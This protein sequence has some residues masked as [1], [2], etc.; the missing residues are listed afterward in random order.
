MPINWPP[1]SAPPWPPLEISNNW[2]SYSDLL[3]LVY[4]MQ[5]AGFTQRAP[6]VQERNAYFR[7]ARCDD[8]H[9][10]IGRMIV[11]PGGTAYPFAVCNNAQDRELL[12]LWP[13]YSCGW[14]SGTE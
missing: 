12:V 10:V 11:S 2:L 6:T 5:R 1:A 3:S 9:Q 13:P 4:E 7:D 14:Q 8:N